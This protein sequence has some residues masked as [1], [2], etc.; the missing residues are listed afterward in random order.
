MDLSSELSNKV[1]FSFFLLAALLVIVLT[2]MVTRTNTYVEMVS[3]TAEYSN[4]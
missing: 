4:N 2:I 3:G 1:K